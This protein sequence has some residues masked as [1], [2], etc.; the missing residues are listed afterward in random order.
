MLDAGFPGGRM[1]SLLQV[2][3]I[4]LAGFVAVFVAWRL[5]SKQMTLPCPPWLS[6]LVELDNPLF[7]NNR[8]SAI[9]A[10]LGVV[11]GMRV[12]DAGCGPG[13]LTA[14]LARETGPNG[15]VVAIDLMTGM[16]DRA[17][18]KADRWRVRNVEFH[19]VKLGTGGLKLGLFDRAV[20]VT[21]LGE[22]PDQEAALREVWGA[23]KPGG[24]L[25][26]SEVIADPHFQSR[27][28]V[29]ALASKVGFRERARAGG[30]LAYTLYLER[31]A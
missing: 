1:L 8:A 9:I 6:W 10:G 21:V 19:V 27:E 18:A 7:R 16:L 23:L 20:M 5:A 13:R 24:V 25:A 28:H 15:Q 29:I 3:L 12:L 17:R 22:I 11:P 30:R 26:I 2:L 31:P 14:P 4:L